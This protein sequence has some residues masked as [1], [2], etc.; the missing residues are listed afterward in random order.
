MGFDP[1]MQNGQMATLV[2]AC[3][4]V[5]LAAGSLLWQAFTWRRSGPRIVVHAS[6]GGIY[7]DGEGGRRTVAVHAVNK[8]RFPAQVVGWAVIFEDGVI[9]QF[10]SS[11]PESSSTPLTLAPQHQATWY[12]DWDDLRKTTKD[13]SQIRYV[14]GQVWLGTGETVTSKEQIDVPDIPPVLVRIVD[15]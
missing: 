5:A 2:I 11:L 1:R 14:K 8:G 13:P 9:F 6:H 15:P 10:P 7:R 4:G 3:A 12:A